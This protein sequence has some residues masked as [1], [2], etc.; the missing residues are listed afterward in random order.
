MSRYL[1]CDTFCFYR[2]RI[3]P[4]SSIGEATPLLSL[5]LTMISSNPFI[6]V[7]NIITGV[8]NLQ[9]FK[10]ISVD[11]EN[12]KI[13]LSRRQVEFNETNNKK[14]TLFIQNMKQ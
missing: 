4:K 3:S 9:G 5:L 10:V 6:L 12:N 11:K 14:I 13:Y 7:C 8:L 2:S 1:I